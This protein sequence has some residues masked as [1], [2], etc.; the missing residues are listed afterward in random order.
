MMMVQVLFTLLLVKTTAK[1]L[2]FIPPHSHK[3]IDPSAKYKQYA[4]QLVGE[5]DANQATWFV[6]TQWSELDVTLEL[7]HKLVKL[8]EPA[9]YDE[10]ISDASLVELSKIWFKIQS[11][12]TAD[13]TTQYLLW[14]QVGR[15]CDSRQQERQVEL[16][17]AKTLEEEKQA[18]EARI[19][20]AEEEFYASQKSC[21]N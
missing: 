21:I 8:C 16:R 4:G 3:P 19:Q 1:D 14:N 20:Q 13:K 10:I 6:S 2:T 9:D 18:K 7:M 5:H 15:P 17:A 11:T 12:Q